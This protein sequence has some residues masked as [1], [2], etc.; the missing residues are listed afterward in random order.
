MQEYASNGCL[1]SIGRDWTLKELEMAT[2]R[3]PHILALEPDAIAQIQVEAREKEAQGFSKIYLWEDLKK[4]L[5]KNLKLSPLA[6]IPHK[7]RKYRAILDLSFA[8]MMTGYNLPSVNEATEHIAPKEAIDQ[9]GTVL[10]RLIKAMASSLLDK[11]NV[12]FS[13]LDIK[14]RFGRMT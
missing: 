2:E 8:L 11:G 3:G 9:I 13:K 6:M 12:M 10:P 7:S 5:P 4:H 1:L 14:D